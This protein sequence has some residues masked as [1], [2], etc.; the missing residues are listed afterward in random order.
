MSY[1]LPQGFQRA[2]LGGTESDFL[3]GL[4]EDAF[5]DKG[6]IWAVGH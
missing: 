6:S 2:V 4:V 3:M 1:L 5:D